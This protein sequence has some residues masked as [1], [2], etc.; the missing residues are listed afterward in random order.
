VCALF[1]FSTGRRA[2]GRHKCVCVMC[3][4][5]IAL[6]LEVRVRMTLHE[7]FSRLGV[8]LRG[9]VCGNYSVL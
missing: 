4:V 3:G 1:A 6:Y 5:L 8:W 9:A 7:C 2:M